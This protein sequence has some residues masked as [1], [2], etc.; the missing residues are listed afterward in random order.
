MVARDAVLAAGLRPEM[1]EYFATG[2]A[3]GILPR[4]DGGGRRNRLAGVADAADV[5]FA[6]VAL[7]RACTS[8]WTCVS[9][10][11]GTS[12]TFPCCR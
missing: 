12:N 2:G 6:A 8:I 7:L 1:M 5:Y 3:Q 4:G 10:G 11:T 9:F